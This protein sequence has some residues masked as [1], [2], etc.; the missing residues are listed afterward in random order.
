MRY[1]PEG[2]SLAVSLALL[3]RYG[4]FDRYVEAK[5]LRIDKEAAE[6]AKK[7]R[8]LLADPTKFEEWANETFKVSRMPKR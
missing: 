8:E 4:S 6:G 2:S 1:L 3:G 5:K 7:L